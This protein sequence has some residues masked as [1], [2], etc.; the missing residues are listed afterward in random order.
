MNG[1]IKD[2]SV[3]GEG[4]KSVVVC[5]ALVAVA[6]VSSAV[7]ALSSLFFTLVI[8]AAASAYLADVCRSPVFAAFAAACSFLLPYV[9]AN[10]VLTGAVSLAIVVLFGALFI[11][12]RRLSLGFFKSSLILGAA[13]LLITA[14]VM[15]ISLK[16]QFGS[17]IEGA[18]LA[19]KEFYGSALENFRNYLSS[20]GG[21]I[22]ISDNQLEELLSLAVTMLPGIIAAAFELFGAAVYMIFKLFYR[23]LGTKAGR[24]EGEY[25]IPVSAI[26]FFAFSFLLSMI[27]SVAEALMIPRLAAVNICIALAPP[28]LLDGAARLTARIKNPASVTLPDGS[29]LKRPPIFLIAAIVLSAFMSLLFPIVIL[30]VYSVVGTIKDLIKNKA[31]NNDR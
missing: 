27:F 28:T 8:A 7:S 4:A 2:P 12:C 17:V 14:G 16:E 31:D 18:K 9:I 22:S 1:N 29:S 19:A 23:I 13:L 30:L 6:A 10:S 11:L 25:K 3:N 26:I 15:A 21:T 5:I 24:V 20:N